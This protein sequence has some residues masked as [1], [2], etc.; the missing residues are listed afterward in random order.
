[1]Q[2]MC[3]RIHRSYKA[4]AIQL[5]CH[6]QLPISCSHYLR[7]WSCTPAFTYGTCLGSQMASLATCQCRTRWQP[8]SMA[9]PLTTHSE[10]LDMRLGPGGRR[11]QKQKSQTAN[12]APVSCASLRLCISCLGISKRARKIHTTRMLPSGE[13]WAF[14]GEENLAGLTKMP[15][16][17]D[18]LIM[19]HN[20]LQLRRKLFGKAS[21][22]RFENLCRLTQPRNSKQN[23][24]KG[25][26]CDPKK[27][28]LPISTIHMQQHHQLAQS[29]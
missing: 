16:R 13:K 4:M 18:F 3:S 9:M 12:G 14:E 1:M 7:S 15:C 10:N 17:Q 8:T 20:F 21:S 5:H 27:S 23:S 25:N 11:L 29:N 24:W 28:N 6:Y 22:H 26:P 19:L 2:Q